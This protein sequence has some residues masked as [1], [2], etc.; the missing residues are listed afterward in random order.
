MKPDVT[1]S[2]THSPS[3]MVFA[4]MLATSI[5]PS[6]FECENVRVEAFK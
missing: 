5:H 2:V 4:R 3:K 1:V 6:E